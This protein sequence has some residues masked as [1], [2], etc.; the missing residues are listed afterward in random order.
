VSETPKAK[1]PTI[2]RLSDLQPGERGD[3]FAL[4]IERKPGLTQKGKPYYH[5][6]FRDARRSASFM[7]W[8]DD[9]WYAPCEGEWHVGQFFKLRAAYDEHPQYGQQIEVA[10]LRPVNDAD[11]ESGFDESDFVETSRHDLNQLW[12]ELRTAA[13]KHVHDETLRGL[14]VDLLE[15]HAERLRTMPAS[16][17]RAYP[18]RG[19]WLE[20]TVSVTRLAVDLAERYAQAWPELRP[21]LNRDLIAAGAILHDLGRV[22]ELEGEAA[23]VTQTVEGRLFGH[24]LMGRDLVRDA[25]REAGLEGEALMLLEHVLLAPLGLAEAEKG[26]GPAIPEALI[27]QAAVDLDLK[28]AAAARALTRDAGPGPFT[29][30]DVSVGRPLLKRRQ[31]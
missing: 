10:N 28:M 14:V 5:C 12:A 15:T 11:R 27:V 23:A 8:S 4:L 20:H 3:F 13:N 21:P 26:R 9:K 6:R 31:T 29:E 17:D 16:K 25:A 19:G 1:P 24:V 2:T 18:Y 22:C 7:V 30:R